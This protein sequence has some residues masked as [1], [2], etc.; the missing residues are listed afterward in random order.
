[1]VWCSRIELWWGRVCDT[2]YRDE[3]EAQVKGFHGAKYKK[4]TQLHEAQEFAG[5]A[6]HSPTKPS[7]AAEISPTRSGAT[8]VSPYI[9]PEPVSRDELP[10]IPSL[11]RTSPSKQSVKAKSKPPVPTIPSP[12]KNV[13]WIQRETSPDV[14]NESIWNVA[15]SDG[16]CKGNG[17]PGSV[18]GIGVWWGRDD[19]RCAQSVGKNY[20]AISDSKLSSSGI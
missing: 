15:Y 9:R 3:C 1:M 2:K 16:A 12:T 14:A 20:P 4:F 5:Q 11:A 6:T 13:K 18:A 17:Q 8:R 10:T 19:P 7:P